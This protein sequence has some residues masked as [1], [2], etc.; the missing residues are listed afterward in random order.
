VLT[1]AALPGSQPLRGTDIEMLVR[2][3]R[4][5]TESVTPS[6]GSCFS[7]VSGT[8]GCGSRSWRVWGTPVLFRTRVGYK[9][10]IALRE[11]ADSLQEEEAEA[12]WKALPCG[13]SSGTDD[14]IMQTRSATGKIE[15][16]YEVPI[17]ARQALAGSAG[18]LVLHGRTPF[19]FAGT[20]DS[21]IGTYT[22]VH[23]TSVTLVGG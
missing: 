16:K 19:D 2:F 14:Y 3:T 9:L 13:A 20:P 6:Q 15:R 12:R 17:S 22:S 23:T 4:T 18:R 10:V 5:G 7:T 1:V 21:P 8:E 11:Y